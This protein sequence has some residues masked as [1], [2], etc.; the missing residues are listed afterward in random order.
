MDG[1]NELGE[2]KVDDVIST[3]PFS[4]FSPP[5]GPKELR[6][7]INRRQTKKTLTCNIDRSNIAAVSSGKPGY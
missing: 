6:K 5:P 2:A 3:K 1:E 7:E 4:H